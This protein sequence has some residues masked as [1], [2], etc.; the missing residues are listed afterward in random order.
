[1]NN[2]AGVGVAGDHEQIS[3]AQRSCVR[4]SVPAPG[5]ADWMEGPSNALSTPGQSARNTIHVHLRWQCPHGH[6]HELLLCTQPPFK[7]GLYAG[8]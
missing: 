7:L 8:L 1:M 2:H 6:S 4:A 3:R 5:S